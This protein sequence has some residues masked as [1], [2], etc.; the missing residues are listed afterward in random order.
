MKH[1]YL[2]LAAAVAGVLALPVVGYAV[3]GPKNEPKAD[4]ASSTALSRIAPAAGPGVPAPETSAPSSV[5][6][7][8]ATSTAPVM[9]SNSSLGLSTHSPATIATVDAVEME[10]L[11]ISPDQP[12]IVTLDRDAIN[13][14]VGS[15]RNLRVVPDTNRTIVLIPKEPGSTYFRAFDADGKIIMQRHVIVG[16]PKSNYIRIRRACVNGSDK[17]CREY[18]VY[19]CPDMCHEVSVMQGEGTRQSPQ[20]P[21]NAPLYRPQTVSPEQN[22]GLPPPDVDTSG[23]APADAL[24]QPK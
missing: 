18:S 24:Q 8:E 21:D 16:A 12:T 19:Y 2:F 3:F 14:M 9:P 15:N 23:T 10:P 20:V 13:I 17:G 1:S 11:R 7:A 6:P 4:M 22:D 5:I